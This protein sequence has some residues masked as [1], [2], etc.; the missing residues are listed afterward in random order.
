MSITYQQE[1]SLVEKFAVA[2]R[3]VFKKIGKDRLRTPYGYI[4]LDKA[5]D[6]VVYDNEGAHMELVVYVLPDG[7]F[8]S[9][10]RN[11]PEEANGYVLAVNY[12]FCGLVWALS[13][14]GDKVLTEYLL[15]L[16]EA[17]IE[18]VS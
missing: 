7:E 8:G 16:L 6:S 14:E 2:A 1:R 17:V 11:I 5:D 9:T 10:M 13:H 15:S 4:Y 18:E 3:R 12:G